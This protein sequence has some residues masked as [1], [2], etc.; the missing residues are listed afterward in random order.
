MVWFDY[1][2]IRQSNHRSQLIEKL[3]RLITVSQTETH[4]VDEAAAAQLG[5]NRTDLRCLGIVLEHEPISASMIAKNAG[6]TRGAMTTALDRLERA[7]LV[8]R[9]DDPLDRRGV[10]VEATLSAKKAVRDIWG[11][12]RT[13]GLALLKE[14][15]DEEIELLDRFFDEYRSLQHSHAERIRHLKRR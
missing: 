3:G 1:Q 5:I 12:I 8:R 6:L 4:E 7:G 11:P 13:D 9:I 10:N 14:Y 15:G 2:M